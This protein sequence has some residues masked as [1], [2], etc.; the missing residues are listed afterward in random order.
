MAT[1]QQEILTNT[2]A[3]IEAIVPAGDPE[4]PF[5]RLKHMDM[6]DAPRVDRAHRKFTVMFGDR[7]EIRPF[8]GHYSEATFLRQIA[9]TIIYRVPGRDPFEIDAIIADDLDRI[10][11]ALQCVSDY[12]EVAAGGSSPAGKV[13]RRDLA[14]GISLDTDAS[15]GAVIAGLLFDIEYRLARS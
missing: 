7:Y 12:P 4:H 6:N 13:V 1:I 9:V 11:W 5:E 10:V 8:T 2:A 15:D 3:L 14:G